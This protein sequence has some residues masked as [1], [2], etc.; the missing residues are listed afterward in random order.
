[1]Y[2]SLLSNVRQIDVPE[3]KAGNLM[4]IKLIKSKS[5]IKPSL[6]EFYL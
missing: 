3:I 2:Q 5:L 1:M 4:L 6:P